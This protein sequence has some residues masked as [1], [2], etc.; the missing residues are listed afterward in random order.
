MKRTAVILLLVPVL[1]LGIVSKVQALPAVVSLSITRCEQEK[2]KWCWAAG[3]Q[4]VGKYYGNNY[5]QSKIVYQI[6]SS[7]NNAGASDS[8]TTRAMNYVLPS[9]KDATCINLISQNSMQTKLAQGY[10]VPI[11]M[12]WDS[13]GSHLVVVSGYLSN[14]NITITDPAEGCSAKNSYSYTALV[15]GTRISSG[16]GKY[17]R[18]WLITS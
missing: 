13:G 6:K 5:S 9:G 7:Y 14:G 2:S 4:M 12:T 8:E 17:V 1:L 11:K 18:T 10:P 16:T 15:N 3:A